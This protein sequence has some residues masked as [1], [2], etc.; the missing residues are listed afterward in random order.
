MAQGQSLL[1]AMDSE[2]RTVYIVRNSTH[3]PM[4]V[5]ARSSIKGL[6]EED[7]M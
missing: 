5:I 6:Y 7:E 1:N 3:Y 2:S 4:R